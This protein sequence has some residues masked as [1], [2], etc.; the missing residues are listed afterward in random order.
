MGVKGSLYL[1]S[2]KSL[3]PDTEISGTFPSVTCGFRLIKA[4]PHLF[5]PLKRK[6]VVF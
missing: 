3:R 5:F 6:R 1:N 4:D 2:D